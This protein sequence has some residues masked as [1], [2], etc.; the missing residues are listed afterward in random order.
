ML[1]DVDASPKLAPLYDADAAAPTA[2]A[3]IVPRTPSVIV[4]AAMSGDAVAANVTGA[5]VL[6][7]VSATSPET[8]QFSATCAEAVALLTNRPMA[9]A[10]GRPKSL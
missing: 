6:V 1:A 4:G 10:A 2:L 3:E 8:D 7:D 5:L 9:L